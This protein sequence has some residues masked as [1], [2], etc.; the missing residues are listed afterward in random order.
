MLAVT[1]F[2]VCATPK[3]QVDVVDAAAPTDLAPSA[4]T[5]CFRQACSRE[6]KHPTQPDSDRFPPARIVG[7]A[8]SRRS[9]TAIHRPTAA[10]ASISVSTATSTQ[11][12]FIMGLTAAVRDLA[13]EP[14]VGFA[15]TA[16]RCLRR[17]RRRSPVATGRS[18]LEAFGPPTE[19]LFPHR[20]PGRSKPQHHSCKASWFALDSFLKPEA[21]W[22]R[23]EMIVQP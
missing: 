19:S 20:R 9:I 7:R 8:C 5:A 13:C 18:P 17:R 3:R 6:L 15:A 11:V 12:V 4:S 14:W 22:P 2:C 10:I 23:D 16:H 1:R 21:Q